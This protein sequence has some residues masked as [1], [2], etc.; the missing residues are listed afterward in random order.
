MYTPKPL[1]WDDALSTGDETL[2]NQ[3][4]YLVATL[5]ELGEAIAQEHGSEI[6]ARILGRL[7]F[8]AGWHLGREEECF[9]K[10]H[11][12]AAE[13]NKKAHE[14]FV[15]KFDKFHERFRETGGSTKMA[16]NIHEEISDWIVN[17]IMIVDGELYP[18]I[19]L[20]PKPTKK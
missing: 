18:C 3:H 2:D 13:K 15:Q 9:D 8:Y 6:I 5:N 19:H 14:V 16:L 10:Y 17:H 20:R 1:Q 11:C 7:R 12:P 4:K